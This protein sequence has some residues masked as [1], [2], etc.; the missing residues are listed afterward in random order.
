M[1]NYILDEDNNPKLVPFMEWA[2]WMEKDPSRRIIARDEVGECVISTVFLGIDHRFMGGG[3]PILFE[4]MI[5][6]QGTFEGW[7]D[8][9]TRCATYEE[10]LEMHEKA[11]QYVKCGTH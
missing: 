10:A 7:E 1:D 4:T 2:Q 6:K 3:P 9:Q 5:F 8:Y 11:I